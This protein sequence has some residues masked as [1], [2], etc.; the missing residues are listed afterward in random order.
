M[1]NRDLVIDVLNKLPED[2]PIQEIIR[3]IEFVSGV[4]EGREQSERD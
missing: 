1:S 3:Q 2:A 4:K